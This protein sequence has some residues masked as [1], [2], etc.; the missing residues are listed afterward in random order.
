MTRGS[1][2]SRP[3]PVTATKQLV[4]HVQTTGFAGRLIPEDGAPVWLSAPCARLRAGYWCD[5]ADG[6]DFDPDSADS[7]PYARVEAAV[8]AEP[9]RYHEEDYVLAGP[10]HGWAAP[11]DDRD[12]Q[13]Q[14]DALPIG[15]VVER[16]GIG[17]APRSDPEPQWEERS[18]PD[19]YAC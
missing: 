2:R 11:A 16:H 17:I 9:V 7:I 12:L 1:G 10:R 14:L 8:G 15:T 18:W 13:R 19:D 5:C 4:A 6:F 3:Q